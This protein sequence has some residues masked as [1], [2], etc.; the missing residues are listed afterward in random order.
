MKRKAAQVSEA[1]S[2][3]ELE[4]GDGAA[5]EEDKEDEN[6]TVETATKK[7]PKVTKESVS[8]RAGGGGICLSD[9]EEEK[10]IEEK[11]KSLES[12]DV[13]SKKEDATTSKVEKDVEPKKITKSD[14]LWAELENGKQGNTGIRGMGSVLN[15]MNRPRKVKE[16][17]PVMDKALEF[18]LQGSKN[19]SVDKEKFAAAAKLA[20]EKTGQ[21]TVEKQVK[22]AGGVMNVTKIVEKASDEAAKEVERKEKEAKET[23]LD[24]VVNQIGEKKGISTL[25]KSSFD[26]DKYK[27]EKGIEEEL[28][29]YAKDGYV[30]KQEFLNRVDQRKFEQEKEERNRQRALAAQ[31]AEASKK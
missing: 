4:K 25:E 3:S 14:A 11:S 19:S 8:A 20:L 15:F 10:E 30:E 28:E 6:F 27:K 5:N 7:K 1:L 12:S 18:M 21:T 24:K 2:R 16:S 17:G 22:F 13:E 26:W 23:A 9:E 31:K 29:K